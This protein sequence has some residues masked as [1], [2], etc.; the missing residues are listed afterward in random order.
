MLYTE[1]PGRPIYIKLAADHVSVTFEKVPVPLLISQVDEALE[2]F[3]SANWAFLQDL[4]WDRYEYL[5]ETPGNIGQLCEHLDEHTNYN[6]DSLLQLGEVLGIYGLYDLI[7]QE[8]DWM[9]L[10]VLPALMNWDLRGAT[11]STD[12]G[13]KSAAWSGRQWKQAIMQANQPQ[14]KGIKVTAQTASSSSFMPLDQT[15]PAPNTL[16]L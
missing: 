6:A 7:T 4:W 8:R 9:R 15:V 13:P 5:K 14:M 11:P 12:L 2:A 1:L 3:N 10:S 16:R